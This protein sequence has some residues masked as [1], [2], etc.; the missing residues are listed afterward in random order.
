MSNASMDDSCPMGA[1]EDVSKASSPP[2]VEVPRWHATIIKLHEL[3]TQ[4]LID[5]ACV[6]LNMIVVRK[7]D[8]IFQLKGVFGQHYQPQRILLDSGDQLLM[9][10]KGTMEGLG[11]T[12]ANLESCPYA[13]LTS[14]GGLE[15]A[16]D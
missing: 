16:Q 7:E 11:S 1:F 9:L 6:H 4:L 3:L 5:R 2:I 13:I 14:M 15:W 10:G 8:G 12:N